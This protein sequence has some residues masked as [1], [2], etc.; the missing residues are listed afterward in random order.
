M[1]YDIKDLMQFITMNEG[2]WTKMY[3]DS[4]GYHTIGIGHNLDSMPI[5]DKAVDL[6]FE[7]DIN[8]AVSEIKKVILD[9]DNIDGPRQI[10]LIDMMLNKGLPVFMRSTEFLNAIKKKDW[11]L[12]A[13][14]CSTER[15]RSVKIAKILR[16]G[17]L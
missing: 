2:R 7:D 15:P 8:I 16:E 6:I 14:E 10:A 17:K 9:F 3:L 11:E 5:S 12:A 1:N 4:K 13:S